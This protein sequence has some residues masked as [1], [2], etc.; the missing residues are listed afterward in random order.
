MERKEWI[1]FEL[2]MDF[3]SVH[4]A[5]QSGLR[6]CVL[7]SHE[8]GSDIKSHRKDIT[9]STRRRTDRVMCCCRGVEYASVCELYAKSKQECNIV[10]TAIASYQL[11]HEMV[12]LH[13]SYSSAESSFH[14]SLQSK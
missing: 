1:S 3:V 4:T 9:P 11:N 13:D 5:V 14:T 6:R 12:H 8:N 7:G 10:I 2:S